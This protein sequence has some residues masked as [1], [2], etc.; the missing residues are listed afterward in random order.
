MKVFFSFHNNLWRVMMN[1][2]ITGS[3]GGIGFETGMALIRKGNFVYFTVHRNSQIETTI[4]KLRDFNVLENYKVFKL[5]ITVEEDRKKLYDLD[6]DVLINNAAIGI[7]GSVLD[8]DVSN[9]KDNF[10]VNVFSTIEMIKLYA[11]SLQ[12][13]NKKGRI[14][15]MS[16]LAGIISLPFMASYCAT[17]SALIS[18]ATSLKMELSLKKTNMEVCLIEPG[19]YVTGFNEVMIDN[20]VESLLFKKIYP[21]VNY[22]QKKLFKVFGKKRLKSI[23]SMVFLIQ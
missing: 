20:K 13:R 15:I 22:Y 18:I 9:I 12:N 11:T 6:I 21:M 14:I 1:I 23:T 17:K 10:N 16:S 7:G 2:L 4:K 19:I 8:L 3:S 5:D